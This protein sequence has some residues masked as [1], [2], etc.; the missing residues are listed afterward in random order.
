MEMYNYMQLQFLCPKNIPEAC[1]TVF[2]PKHT[3]EALRRVPDFERGSQNHRSFTER[4]DSSD[5]KGFDRQIHQL[6]RGIVK[7]PDMCEA[8]KH[9]SGANHPG[10]HTMLQLLS[11]EVLAHGLAG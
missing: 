5:E 3:P 1:V 7:H 10:A 2:I 4:G 9:H 8:V 6:A 11:E